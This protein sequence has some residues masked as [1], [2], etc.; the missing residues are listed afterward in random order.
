M[1]FGTVSSSGVASESGP[2]R[3]IGLGP[4]FMDSR[5][6]T[7][8]RGTSAQSSA[9]SSPAKARRAL[10][11][12]LRNR[13]ANGGLLDSPMRQTSVN[14]RQTS[15]LNLSPGSS[16]SGFSVMYDEPHGSTLSADPRTKWRIHFAR[17]P[18]SAKLVIGPVGFVDL[19][20][21]LSL[22]E[23]TVC[24]LFYLIGAGT[25]VIC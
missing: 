4:P 1:A 5:Q 21:R 25:E 3:G 16:E 9:A 10:G 2:G 11:T 19:V 22:D 20:D 12:P 24:Y 15:M 17:P 6:T 23:E 18:I 14:A 13:N 7:P 8:R